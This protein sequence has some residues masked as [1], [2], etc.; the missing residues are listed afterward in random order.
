MTDSQLEAAIASQGREVPDSWKEEAVTPHDHAAQLR[1]ARQPEVHTAGGAGV[2]S[3]NAP[4]PPPLAG[5]IGGGETA[6][7]KPPPPRF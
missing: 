4:T 5:P 2:E 7:D 3:G 6:F 1:S